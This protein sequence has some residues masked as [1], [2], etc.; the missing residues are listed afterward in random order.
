MFLHASVKSYWKSGDRSRHTALDIRRAKFISHLS[1]MKTTTYTSLLCKYINNSTVYSLYSKGR[2][3]DQIN[4]YRY[5]VDIYCISQ[6]H[7][8]CLD[9]LQQQFLVLLVSI[10]E[11]KSVVITMIT[12]KS[13]GPDGFPIGWYKTF[14]YFFIPKLHQFQNQMYENR[15][16]PS[17]QYD[18]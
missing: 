16:L 8:P 11:I 14:S 13:P 7:L 6:L 18:D 9:S 17:L 15:A 2:E 1:T 3:P 5:T 10:D 12:D 4:R